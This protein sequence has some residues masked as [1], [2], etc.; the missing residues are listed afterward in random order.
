MWVFGYGSL[1][2]DGWEAQHGCT[3]K[4]RASLQGFRREFNKASRENWGTSEQ[5]GPTL[6]LTTDAAGICEGL[7]FEIPDAQQ[8]AVEAYL[9]QREGPSFTLQLHD[10]NL[11]S[12]I[13]VRALVPVNDASKVT[14]IGG[15]SLPER[16]R[17]AKIAYGSSGA[18]SEYVK[19]IR[20]KLGEL[21]IN[22]SAVESFWSAVKSA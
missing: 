1:M 2:W 11:Q 14:Y 12:G 20:E 21:G 13:S 16:A 7:V 4:E 9:K 5:P 6:G 8:A 22:D 17:M 18:C 19:N 10:V 15:L 3:R